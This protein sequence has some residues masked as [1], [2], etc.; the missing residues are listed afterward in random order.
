MT[1]TGASIPP[2]TRTAPEKI[3]L[4]AKATDIGVMSTTSCARLESG[5]V[6]CW[7]DMSYEDRIAYVHSDPPIGPLSRM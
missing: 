2:G 4:P 3:P 7:A 1:R 5:S 6:H